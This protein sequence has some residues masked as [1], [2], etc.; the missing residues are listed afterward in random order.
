MEWHNTS[1]SAVQRDRQERDLVKAISRTENVLD[2]ARQNNDIV[3]IERYIT[4]LARQK[5]NLAGIQRRL[6]SPIAQYDGVPEFM[7]HVL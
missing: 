6:S 5:E 7:A 2:R 4:R 1:D 3:A